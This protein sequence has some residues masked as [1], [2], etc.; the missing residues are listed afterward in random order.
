MSTGLIPQISEPGPYATSLMSFAF[1]L[2]DGGPRHAVIDRKSV[3]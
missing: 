2:P 3:V 1:L